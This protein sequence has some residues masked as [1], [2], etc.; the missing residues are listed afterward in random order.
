MN[1]KVRV[2]QSVQRAINIINCF[3]EENTK[4]TLN[5]LSSLLDLNINTTRGIVNTLVFNGY[6]EHEPDTNTYSLGIVFIE[7]N[8]LVQNK[9]AK[10]LEA[11]YYPLLYKVANE[12]NVSARVQLV[13][14]YT[15]IT[16]KTVN[17]EHTRYKL[18]TYDSH[19]PLNATSS[20]K[21]YLYYLD[22]DSKNS[23]LNNIP[24]IK[25]SP[26]TKTSKSELLEELNFIEAN[27]YA[28][29]VEEIDL[30]INSV[31]LPITNSKDELIGTISITGLSTIISS[32]CEDALKDIQEYIESQKF[33]HQI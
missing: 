26:K 8:K 15:I 27:G 29:E 24:E 17:P 4:L 3:N 10:N 13:S 7:K 16:L 28:R 22:E 11:I 31:A 9:N 25:Y 30:G 20:G 33:Q 21:L 2:I 1:N 19:F 18:I 6:L 12:Y 32:I 14:N 5:D 23:F